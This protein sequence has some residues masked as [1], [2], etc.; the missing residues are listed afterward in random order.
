MKHEVLEYLKESLERKYG[1][2]ED[3]AGCYVRNE[4]GEPEWLSVKEIVRL[5]DEADEEC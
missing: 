1:D 4:F 2:L 5:I 3:D